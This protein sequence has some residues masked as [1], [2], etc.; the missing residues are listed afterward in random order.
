MVAANNEWKMTES[1]ETCFYY[2]HPDDKWREVYIRW[3]V[4]G[5]LTEDRY[6]AL[7]AAGAV[8]KPAS[9]DA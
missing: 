1:A 7:I 2:M 5:K 3:E 6:K 8:Y 4:T 9:S